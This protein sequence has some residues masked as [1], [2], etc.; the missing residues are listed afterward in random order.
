[1]LEEAARGKRVPDE[2]LA[3]VIAREVRS[4]MEREGNDVREWVCL[5]DLRVATLERQ[6]AKIAGECQDRLNSI[7]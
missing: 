4:A 3:Q 1:M 7:S 6:N 2:H 5:Q